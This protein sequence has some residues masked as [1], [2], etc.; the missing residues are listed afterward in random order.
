MS[1][2]LP[3]ARDKSPR[4]TV[5]PGHRRVAAIDIGSNS[6]RQIVADVSPD[7]AI[8]VVDEMKAAPRLGAGLLATG[9]LSATVD[10]SRARSASSAW[11]RSRGSSAPSASTP[12]RRAP[13]ATPRTPRTSS[14]AFAQDAGCSV[15]VL[16]GDDEARLSFR[17]ALAHFDLGVGRTVVMDIGGGSLELALERRRR[18]R[19]SELPPLRRD[20]T[21]REFFSDGVTPKRVRKLRRAVSAGIR[22]GHSAPRLARRAGHRLGRD[23]HQPRGNP[24][25][26]TGHSH[27][28]QQFTT[29]AFRARISSTSSTCSPR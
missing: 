22:D 8:H 10:A 28:A 24:P 29:R 21:D 17:S 15:R 7:G 23:L 27:G 13:C 19:A 20:S 18:D 5:S 14:R 25:L 1:A 26:A 9:E 2:V 3:I 11:R 16:D 12:S 6:I 4:R